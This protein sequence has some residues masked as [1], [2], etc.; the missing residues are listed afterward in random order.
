[1]KRFI[2]THKTKLALAGLVVLLLVGL[3]AGYVQ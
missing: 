3:A 2:Q 1:M